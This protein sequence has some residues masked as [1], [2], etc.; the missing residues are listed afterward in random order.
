MHPRSACASQ[1]LPRSAP[2]LM[3]SL[4]ASASHHLGG[5]GNRLPLPCMNAATRV[6]LVLPVRL[7]RLAERQRL[8]FRSS[9]SIGS[10]RK[11]LDRAY[12]LDPAQHAFTVDVQ[13]RHTDQR[14]L[15]CA[16]I[17]HASTSI[18]A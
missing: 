10:R 17:D 8:Q 12:V 5:R 18:T 7:N 14:R 1:V 11:L 16:E 15:D 9:F 4:A 2:P 13:R 3:A 6:W